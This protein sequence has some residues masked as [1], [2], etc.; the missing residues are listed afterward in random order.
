ML[1]WIQVFV[2]TAL[3]MVVGYTAATTSLNK[4]TAEAFLEG[5][6]SFCDLDEDERLKLCPML[7]TQENEKDAS[8]TVYRCDEDQAF[9]IIKSPTSHMREKLMVK[10]F[11]LGS[12]NIKIRK[13]CKKGNTEAFYINA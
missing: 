3:A 4:N 10:F 1:K 11:E 6:T 9:V 13:L 8:L 12:K 5:K 7:R 2:M